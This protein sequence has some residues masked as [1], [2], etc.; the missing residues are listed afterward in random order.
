MDTKKRKPERHE[1][2]PTMAMTVRTSRAMM[3]MKNLF[4][5]RL[6]TMVIPKVS[7]RNSAPPSRYM[8]TAVVLAR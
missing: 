2:A 6:L 3:E 5:C 8:D 1:L 7:M 4:Q